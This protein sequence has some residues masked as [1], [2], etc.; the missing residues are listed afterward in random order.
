MKGPRAANV[1]PTFTDKRSGCP[2]RRPRA[3]HPIATLPRLI[4]DLKVC[5]PELQREL[6]PH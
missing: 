1:L 4:V 5:T 2:P 6:V 3:F